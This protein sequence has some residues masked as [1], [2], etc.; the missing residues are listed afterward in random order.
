MTHLL[1]LV[2]TWKDVSCKKATKRQTRNP[3]SFLI[4]P[5]LPPTPLCL[6]MRL[7]WWYVLAN[8]AMATLAF[9]PP[10]NEAICWVAGEPPTC[11]YRLA[12]S[13]GKKLLNLDTTNITL[14]L[15]TSDAY[16]K[17]A[18]HLPVFLMSLTRQVALQQLHWTHLKISISIIPDICHKHHKR[19]LWRK[20]LS[21]GEIVP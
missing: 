14:F 8:T 10:D 17:L 6:P 18:K 11:K 13:Q 3:S 16:P 20:N 7:E 1:V 5:P 12:L 19:C 21:C 2:L 15:P 4:S 9:C